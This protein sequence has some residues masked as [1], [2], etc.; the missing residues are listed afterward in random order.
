MSAN[1]SL[2]K[3]ATDFLR[4]RPLTG[5]QS[6]QKPTRDTSI[7]K[8][9]LHMQSQNQPII[10]LII[11]PL[12]NKSLALNTTFQS[13]E[14]MHSQNVQQP[15]RLATHDFQ[16]TQSTANEASAVD[17]FLLRLSELEYRVRQ[18]ESYIKL[19]DELREVKSHK[20]NENK[21]EKQ[22]LFMA[23]ADRI[24]ECE[25]GLKG[26]DSK[27]EVSLKGT[28]AKIL[29]SNSQLVHLKEAIK[30][31]EVKITESEN[32]TI[33]GQLDLTQSLE[34]AYSLTDGLKDE[35]EDKMQKLMARETR[36]MIEFRELVE[37][38]LASYQ[39]EVRTEQVKIQSGS[40]KQMQEVCMMIEE[41]AK[42]IRGFE[43]Q[44][45][46]MKSQQEGT[47][48]LLKNETHRINELEKQSL[49][50]NQTLQKRV[51]E[52]HNLFQT[53]VTHIK[54]RH[55]RLVSL[56]STGLESKNQIDEEQNSE[57]MLTID[58][59][60]SSQGK[61]Q[62]RQEEFAQSYGQRSLN[63]QYPAQVV[64]C[65]SSQKSGKKEQQQESMQFMGGT[66]ADQQYQLPQYEGGDGIHSLQD[67]IRLNEG[68]KSKFEQLKQQSTK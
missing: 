8:E 20:A 33:K 6:P 46:G 2:N 31:I 23:L 16:L 64:S 65:Q 38:S 22:G 1:N 60:G 44:L 45:N 11:N 63:Y 29:E 14:Q 57:Q 62:S 13:A 15:Q 10:D 58:E 41:L 52:M 50:T 24:H 36:K 27:I 7:G 61:P 51:E 25:L 19:S 26:I 35:L 30:G 42:V 54:R 4:A 9:N 66:F 28:E 68:L 55:A 49:Q 5:G 21:R 12:T 3:A 37:N 59:L 67:L 39:R 47:S 34:K 43:W 17:Y 48:Q 56:Y 18:T 40:E 53:E 32:R